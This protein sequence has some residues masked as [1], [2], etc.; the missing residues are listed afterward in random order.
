MGLVALDDDATASIA[1]LYAELTGYL[2][3][4]FGRAH[5]R[6]V[7]GEIQK[8]AEHRSGHCY[9]DLVD[10]TSSG[11]DAPTLKTKCWRTTWSSIRLAVARAGL[12]LEEGMVVRVKGYVDVYA[13]RGELGFIITALDL[14]ALRGSVLGEHARRRE[15]LIK[16]LVIEGLFDANRVVPMSPVPLRVGLVASKETEGCSDFLGM[17]ENSGFAFRVMLVHAVVQGA[18]A[19][20]E[21]ARAIR[22][23]GQRD[24]DVICVVRGGG[25]HGDL[26]AFDDEVVAR[27]IATCEVPVFTGI[28]HTGDVSVADLVASQTFRTP[29]ACGEALGA[30]VREWYAEHVAVASRRIGDAAIGVVDELDADVEQSRRHLVA[31]GRHQLA[32]ADQLRASVA[33]TVARRA[34][35]ALEQV[36]ATLSA[37]SRRLAPLAQRH[38]AKAADGLAARRSL[39]AAYDPARLLARGWSITTDESGKIVRSVEGLVPGLVLATRLTD[40]VARSTVTGVDRDEAEEA[41]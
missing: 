13:P 19:P 6:W 8:Y 32:R 28:G 15:A 31:V 21:V 7:F 17:L 9:L 38:T 26:G 22:S 27:A 40:G 41:T 11:R 4:G 29:T 18:R 39:L 10:P 24:C 34:P 23:L 20:L 14:E 35:H 30:V 16:S 2:D 5:Q 33:A 12:E 36:T 3:R 1:Q 25:S 37:A